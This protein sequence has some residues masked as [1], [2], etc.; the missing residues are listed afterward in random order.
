MK[1]S[2]SQ[3]KSFRAC[4]RKWFLESVL[5][6][7][8]DSTQ[9]QLLGTAMHAILEYES[10]P[11][12]IPARL[13][14]AEEIATE[15]APGIEPETVGTA[16]KCAGAVWSK[17]WQNRL[18]CATPKTE[19][20]FAFPSGLDGADVEV[21]GIVDLFSS[22]ADAGPTPVKIARI[23]DYKT[24]S[25]EKYIKTEEELADDVQLVTYARWALTVDDFALVVVGHV[26]VTTRHV[27]PRVSVREVCLTADQV[28]SKWDALAETVRD[29]LATSTVAE[30]DDVEPTGVPDACRAYGGCAFRSWCYR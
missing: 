17:W 11:T 26:Y 29:M 3:I 10:S 5:R 6:V 7:R 19:G 20:E 14:R 2:A 22:E 9:A 27:Q 15:A 21:V 13:E 1:I 4:K 30:P 25:S 8:G 24:T 18:D 12:E 16:A 23:Y 28:R